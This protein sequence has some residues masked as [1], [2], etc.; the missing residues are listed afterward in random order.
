[1]TLKHNYIIPLL[2]SV[3][4]ATPETKAYTTYQLGTHI[5]S[6]ESLVINPALSL[7]C[8]NN[9][10]F[11]FYNRSSDIEIGNNNSFIRPDQPN[12][13]FGTIDFGGCFSA[14][15]WI[16]IGAYL[17]MSTL[18]FDFTSQSTSNPVAFPYGRNS[19]PLGGLGG[20]LRLTES[21]YLGLS[22]KIIQSVDIDVFQ[23]TFPEVVTSTTVD[24]RPEYQFV[25]G[26]AYTW[27]DHLFHLSY[28]PEIRGDIDIDI[29]VDI[30]F[31][32]DFDEPDLFIDAAISYTPAETLFGYYYNNHEWIIDAGLGYEQWSKIENIFLDPTLPFGVD[33]FFYTTVDFSLKDTLNPYIQF[34]LPTFFVNQYPGYWTLGYS[35]RP[36]VVSESTTSLPLYGADLHTFKASLY[37]ET[38]AEQY[39]LGLEAKLTYSQLID[40]E[41]PSGVN[42]RGNLMSIGFSGKIMF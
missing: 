29:N 42:V 38:D 22:W 33:D 40:A 11:G 21:T 2:F 10:K 16:T 37:A 25:L 34:S 23:A 17:N 14:V 8:E 19:Q 4:V 3:V 36:S 32:T 15:D 27:N 20:G 30:P 5:G 12:S 31:I 28:S 39:R 18:S 35:F 13:G 6:A 41:D 26:T 9:I 7:F 1:M 24:V